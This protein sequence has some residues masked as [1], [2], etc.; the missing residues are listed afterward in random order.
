M[1]ITPIL[2]AGDEA[3]IDAL[4]R[5]DVRLED[6]TRIYLSH[7]HNDHAGSLRL[8]DATVPVWVQRAEYEYAMG[9]PDP[10]RHGM[11]RI[12]YD[13]PEIDW[14]FMDGDEE[15]APGIF[16]FSTPGHTP[17]HMSFVIETQ[18]GDGWVFA[19]DAGDLTA[20]FEQEIGPGGLI[21]ATPEQGLASVLRVKQVAAERGL[22]IIPGHDPVVWPQ[23]IRDAGGV[24]PALPAAW[25]GPGVSSPGAGGRAAS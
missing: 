14:R 4:A 15:L 23:L 9:H 18:D 25:A 2:P 16:A 13:D 11:F 20:N 22:P 1:S 24:P 19:F 6:V 5:W 8:F 3:V 21:D 7:L 17:G 12:D 10:E